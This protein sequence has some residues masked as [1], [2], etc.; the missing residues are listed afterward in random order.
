[1]AYDPLEGNGAEAICAQFQAI[2]HLRGNWDTLWANCTNY[3]WPEMEYF[4]RDPIRATTGE[5]RTPRLYD[6]TGTVSCQRFPSVIEGILIP[7]ND[8]WHTVVPPE[9]S[10]LMQNKRVRQYCE[11]VADVLFAARYDSASNFV[12]AA[13][14]YSTSLGAW[15]TGAMYIEIRDDGGAFPLLYRNVPLWEVYLTEGE[16]GTVDTVY[17]WFGMTAHQLL[18]KEKWKDKLP[19]E[20]MECAQKKPSE[21]FEILHYTRKMTPAEEPERA[22]RVKECYIFART[23]VMLEEHYLT[24]WPWAIS[25]FYKMPTEV[26]GRSPLMAVL[27]LVQSL[28]EVQRSFIRQAELIAEPPL[29]VAEED[30]IGS[31]SLMPAA[32]NWGGM[33]AEGRMLIQPIQA[34]GQIQVTEQMIANMQQR[35]EEAFFLSFLRVIEENPDMTATAVMEITAQRGMMLAPVLGR[36]QTEWLEPMVMREIDALATFDMLPDMPDELREIGGTIDL[37]YDNALSR[38]QRAQQ[39]IGIMRATSY[40][41]ELGAVYPPVL[42][43]PDFDEAYRMFADIQGAPAATNRDPR[44]VATIRA[45]RAQ[46]QQAQQQAEVAEPATKALANAAGAMKDMSELNGNAA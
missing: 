9:W 8:R 5:R 28:Q 25:R 18:Q 22:L 4:L 44:E 13:T 12:T 35:V 32:L 26:Y 39:G 2:K 40:A 7:R 16:R 3:T 43:V 30:S 19:P 23:K 46:A 10:G 36:L 21:K 37:R 31:V 34:A 41:V 17:R 38:A 24:S 42:D 33:S 14:E 20:V 15:G 11:A 1:M 6:E 29:A 45:D 27:P